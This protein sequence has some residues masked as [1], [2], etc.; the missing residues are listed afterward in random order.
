M[1]TKFFS[2]IILL[3]AVVLGCISCKSSTAYSTLLKNEKELMADYIKRNHINIIYEEPEYDQWKE[4]DYLEIADYCYFHLSQM[5]DTASHDT[6]EYKDVIELR[7]RRYTLNVNA[8]TISYWTSNDSPYP[9]EFQYGVTSNQA[10]DAW[11][12]AIKHMRFSGAEGKLLCPSKLGFQDGNNVIP[13][14][15]DL[16]IKVRTF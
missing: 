15:Y 9:V 5:G 12:Y 13:Y 2:F 16:K 7:Y 11:H 1:K 4:N 6:I 10:C 14:G 3:T 8:D